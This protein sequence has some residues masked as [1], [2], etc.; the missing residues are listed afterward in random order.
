MEKAYLTPEQGEPI[1]CMFNPE[2]VVVTKQNSWK[3]GDAK[4]K[5]APS[6]RFQSGGSKTLKLN[7][8]FDTTGKNKSVTEYTYR[9]LKLMDVDKR[10]KGTDRKRNKARPPYVEL[11][12]G[13]LLA[14][15]FKAVIESLT[16]TYTYFSKTGVPLRAK[17]DIT[18][19]QWDDE[20][21]LPPQ[22]PTSFSP[23][24]HSV[25]QLRPGETLDRVAAQHY[26][27]AT[28]WRLI[29]DANGILDPLRLDGVTTLA[30]PEQE[31]RHRNGNGGRH[32]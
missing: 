9:L 12:W 19:K 14:E 7:L 31:V 11:W 21:D 28:R 1:E 27:D 17:A 23:S 18:L 15:R 4:G 32:G 16:I 29:A 10:L 24:L 22:N 13:S 5:N 6:L 8:V 26:D 3:G 30:I 2:Q 25:H 20:D